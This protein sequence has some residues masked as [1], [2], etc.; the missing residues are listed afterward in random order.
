MFSDPFV[1]STD[2]SNGA[3]GGVLSQVR[4]GKEHVI[5]YW[6]RQLQKAERNYST[7]EKEALAVV[8]A[9]KEFY[10]YL[11]GFHF[12]LVTDHNPLTALK[13]VKDYGGRLTRWILFLMQFDYEMQYKPGRTHSNADTLSRLPLEPDFV[14]MIQ[15][16]CSLNRVQQAQRTDKH[17]QLI[18]NSLRDNKSLP[19]SIAGLRK[20][21]L[22]LPSFWKKIRYSSCDT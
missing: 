1:L 19:T 14:N 20:T 21:F 22:R 5:A 9:V 16:I 3:V 11:Y 4:N 8:S 2:A 13:G 12:K 6:S 10:P 18:I 15:D 7:I 17:L